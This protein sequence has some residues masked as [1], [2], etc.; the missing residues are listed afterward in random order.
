MDWDVIFAPVEGAIT[1]VIT[2]VMPVAISL[3]VIM[4]GIGIAFWLFRKVGVRR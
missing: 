2:D 4:A 3:F 1:G